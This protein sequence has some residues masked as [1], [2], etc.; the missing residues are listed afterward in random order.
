MATVLRGLLGGS[1][2]DVPVPPLP[3]VTALEPGRFGGPGFVSGFLG[4]GLVAL[5]FAALVVVVAVA[6]VR[7]GARH[8]GGWGTRVAAVLSVAAFATGVVL[9][10]TS[11]RAS[12]TA[13]ADYDAEL[14]AQEAQLDALAADFARDVRAG[15]GVEVP[16]PLDAML[17]GTGLIEFSA[18]DADGTPVTCLASGTRD[19]DGWL[20][21]VECPSPA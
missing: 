1:A 7:L 16:H 10:V 13:Q 19:G 20:I 18:K 8:A 9:L 12:D 15:L 6:A 11:A 14:A 2:I 21:H 5:G 3:E 4:L 17:I